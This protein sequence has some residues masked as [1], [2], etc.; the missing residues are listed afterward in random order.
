[1]A[2]ANPFKLQKLLIEAFANE[3]R[4]KLV[5]QFEAMFNPESLSQNYKN[6][7]SHLQGLITSGRSNK[8]IL[9][10]PTT[11]NLTLILDDTGVSSYGLT[12]LAGAGISALGLSLSSGINTLDNALAD[13]GKN[14]N[15]RLTELLNLVQKYSG[16]LHQSHF[17]KV[18]WG[19]RINGFECFLESVDITYTLFARNGDPLR[20]EVRLSLL[21]DKSAKKRKAEEST[22]SPDLTRFQ[23]VKSS[24]TLPQ[25]AKNIYGDAG[26]YI[27]LAQ[28]NGYDNFRKLREGSTIRVPP[29]KN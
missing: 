24:D 1:M 15:T 28:V 13:A 14:L 16:D 6:I 23:T 22:S 26:Y 3:E 11:L 2:L 5:G 19:S 17:L 9:S 21:E 25:L 4:T 29:L 7:N 10:S 18:T 27:Q 12:K 20:A 8:Y